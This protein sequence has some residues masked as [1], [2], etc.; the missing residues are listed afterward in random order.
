MTLT[1]REVRRL[2]LGL[3]EAEEKPHFERA[4]FRVRGKIFATLPL[5]G[6][7]VVLMLTPQVRESVRQ[8]YPGALLPLPDAWARRGS[9]ELRLEGIPDGLLADLLL[10]AWRK[11][12]P[13]S[14]LKDQ[15]RSA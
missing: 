7:S 1:Q 4:S 5:R 12:A 8:S 9:T 10:S 15:G 6:D 3:P 2:A 14:L 11:V 13:K